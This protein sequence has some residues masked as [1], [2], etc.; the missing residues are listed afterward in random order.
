MQV[1]CHDFDSNDP[2]P[3]TIMYRILLKL[4]SIVL[5]F[6]IPPL[7]GNTGGGDVDVKGG[8]LVG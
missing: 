3:E 2:G 7:L 1:A 6:T 5:E 4:S 8:K